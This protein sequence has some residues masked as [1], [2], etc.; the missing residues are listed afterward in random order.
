MVSLMKPFS[1]Y[2]TNP[3][4]YPNKINY[5]TYYVYDKGECLYSGP[6]WEMSKEELKRKYPTAVIQEIL[7]E[8]KYKEHKE[9]YR[10][11]EQKLYQ[12]FQTDMFEM[13]CVSDNPKR[14]KCFDIAWEKGHAN[15]YSEVY[16]EFDDIVGLIR[17]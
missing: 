9:I 1:Y 10:Q 3:I 7:D 5:I 12:E 2:S 8:E 14:F 15:G 13:F 6:F 17:D 11:A 16:N 4:N